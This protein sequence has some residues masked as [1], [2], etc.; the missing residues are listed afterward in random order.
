ML[1]N[2]GLLL[3]KTNPRLP[4]KVLP[5]NIVVEILITSYSIIAM[6]FVIYPLGIFL[7]K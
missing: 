7:R 4:Y 2:F 3:A 6:N 5:A 1:V